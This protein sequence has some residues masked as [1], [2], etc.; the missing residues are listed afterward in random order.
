MLFAAPDLHRKAPKNL[1]LAEL[2]LLPETAKLSEVIAMVNLLIACQ[3]P[4][5]TR[6]KTQK[7]LLG[8]TLEKKLDKLHKSFKGNAD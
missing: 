5:I 7:K 6:D 8:A 3:K 1:A 2:T 4:S